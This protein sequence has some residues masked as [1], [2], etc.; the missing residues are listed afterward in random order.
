MAPL[1][2]RRVAD[3]VLVLLGI[4]IAAFLLIH[5]VPGDPIHVML[6]LKATPQAVAALRHELHL[7]ESLPAQYATFVKN[8]I[9]FD[10]GQSISQHVSV[11][12]LVVPRLSPTL[13]LTVYAVVVSLLV[14]VPLGVVSA[15][16]RNRFLDHA[17]RLLSMVTFG[18]PSFW[19]GLLFVLA[20]S[21]RLHWLPSSGYGES[22]LAHLR[23]L[24]LPGLTVGL[25]LAPM[26]LRTLRSSVL[27]T[28]SSEFVEAARARGLSERRVVLNHVLRA[29]LI[30]TVTVLGVNVG[31]LLS[32][33]VVVENVFALPGL[34]GLLVSS[35]LGRDFPVVQALAL[36]FGVGVIVVN[37]LTDLLYALLDPR[38]SL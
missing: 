17:I 31:I 6:G 38:V 22:A 5:L 19:L 30:S 33:T 7:D 20:F 35:V 9:R 14:A 4:S 32:G 24:T 18:M 2:L 28:L 27:E 3:S 29:S 13:L 1:L 16:H 36:L 12:S 26:L 37:L 8:A 11:S 23:S 34:G 25:F 21:L 10:F 15:L